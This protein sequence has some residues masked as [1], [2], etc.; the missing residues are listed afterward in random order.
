MADAH[1]F[2][3]KALNQIL[4]NIEN[5][6]LGSVD[7]KNV[8]EKT[9]TN[10]KITGIAGDVIE[11]SVLGYPPDSD[12]RPD[13]IIDGEFVELKT[14]GIKQVGKEKRLVAKEPASITAVS[15]NQIVTEEFRTSAFW[16][17]AEKILFVFY[18]Y[19]SKKT[20]KAAEYADF[21]IKGSY[22]HLFKDDSVE[23]IEKDWLA[24]RDFL[25]DV[26]KK[27]VDEE[28]RKLEYPLLSTKI[29]KQLVY[30]DTAPKY[31]HPPRIRLRKRVMDMIV[32]E[33]FGKASLSL[34]DKYIRYSDV[35]R[36]CDE[37]TR[38]YKGKSIAE[39]L[40]SFDVEVDENKSVDICKQ[41]AERAAVLMF[42]GKSVKK[43]SDIELFQSF[44]YIGHTIAVTIN[45]K[46][47]E[48]VK[49]NSVDF[50]ELL[51][52]EYFDEDKNE[53]RKKEFEDS[54]L[55]NYLHDNKMLCIVFQE[56]VKEKKDHKVKLSENKFVGFRVID[57][58][59]PQIIK[60]AKDAWNRAR[61]TI[62]NGE[63]KNVPILL[64]NGQQRYT[65]KTKI[66]M[67]APNLPKSKE[68]LIFFRGT[69]GDAQKKNV[70][71]EGIQM[72]YQNYWIK[73]DYIVKKLDL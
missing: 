17:K 73:G 33:K 49:L 64:K 37:L 66:P 8:F 13:L 46:R 36:K 54:D 30:L 29:N 15:I 57:L 67:V 63:L 9:K 27:Y 45:G 51:E 18:L 71:I 16:D 19:N 20:V 21:I 53:V 58:S 69:G 7:T 41:Y 32:Q 39:I 55:Y 35:D 68:G 28:S 47:T 2:T 1:E 38:V 44:G 65:P 34:P 42:G 10:P 14:T 40:K 62:F 3:W 60:A 24:I 43:I 11:Q 52:T 23:I 72:Y 61:N 48:D 70:V 26:H 50:N 22:Y 4:K 12:Q 56:T 31:P 5:K 25:K 6:T 59:N